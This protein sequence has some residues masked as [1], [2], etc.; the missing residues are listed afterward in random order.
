MERIGER[1]GGE[2]TCSI[3]VLSLGRL[4]CGLR[5]CL[6]EAQQLEK[7]GRV[8]LSGSSRASSYYSRHKGGCHASCL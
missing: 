4:H 7:G 1:I 5:L 8:T 2:S 6:T 3:M